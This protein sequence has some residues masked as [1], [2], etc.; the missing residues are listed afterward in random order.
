MSAKVKVL[1]KL[2]RLT[3]NDVHD[4]MNDTKGFR[5]GQSRGELYSSNDRRSF[6][7]IEEL[8]R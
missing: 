1:N 5:I 6:L 8:T 7:V 2:M 4:E 3:S